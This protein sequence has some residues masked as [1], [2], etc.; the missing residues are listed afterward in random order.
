LAFIV[1]LAV[2]AY[3]ALVAVVVLRQ[4]RRTD[5]HDD[6][7]DLTS[8]EPPSQLDRARASHYQWQHLKKDDDR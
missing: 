7:V 3:V 5:H 1:S 4:R 6:V 2:L 8:V